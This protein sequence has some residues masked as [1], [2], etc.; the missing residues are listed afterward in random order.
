MKNKFQ[1]PIGKITRIAGKAIVLIG[2]D[3]DTDRI[4]PARFLKCVSFDHLGQS[5]FEDDRKNL[6]VEDGLLK[7]TALRESYKGK[8]FTSARIVSKDLFDFMYG[9]VD[10]KAKL[11]KG[12]GT[13]PAI[14]MIGSNFDEVNWPRSGEIDIMEYD[15]YRK[16]KIHTTVHMANENGD[17]VYFTSIK[18]EINNVSEEFHVYSLEWTSNEL[19]FLIDNI[20]VYSF[21]NS[22][23][24]PFNQKFFL[25]LNV[26]VGGNFVGNR[27]DTD[28]SEGVM[29]IDY[30]RVYK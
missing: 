14:W 20:I 1:A 25:I 5:V 22:S 26:A 19:I 9:R 28:F 23:T 4:I 27:V 18:N 30:V 21:K 16:D 10:V 24:Y 3:I 6:K 29:E 8:E 12:G 7:I 2:D 13:W 15:Y 11:P 17:H